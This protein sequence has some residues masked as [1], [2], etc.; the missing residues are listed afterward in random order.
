MA[1]LCLEIVLAIH[2]SD[3][4]HINAMKIKV[5][6]AYCADALKHMFM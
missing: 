5:S 2:T 4:S 3:T 1:F 6:R